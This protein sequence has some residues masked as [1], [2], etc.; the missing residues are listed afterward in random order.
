MD[1]PLLPS[2]HAVGIA[3]V[4][5]SDFPHTSEVHGEGSGN[6]VFALAVPSCHPIGKLSVAV[7]A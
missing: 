3:E 5:A 2:P 4:N 6:I 7:L 1:D